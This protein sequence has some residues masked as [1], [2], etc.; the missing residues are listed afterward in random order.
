MNNKNNIT[1]RSR[2]KVHNSLHNSNIPGIYDVHVIDE[3]RLTNIRLDDNSGKLNAGIYTLTVNDKVAL[4]KKILETQEKLNKGIMLPRYKDTEHTIYRMDIPQYTPISQLDTPRHLQSIK[5]DR[6]SD[7][8]NFD[9]VAGVFE[10]T[11]IGFAIIRESEKTY[12]CDC[13]AFVI[14]HNGKQLQYVG[15]L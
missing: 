14:S 3:V 11:I 9:L 1:A 2:V 4:F 7:L 8:T 13:D 10:I 15:R 5:I 6:V 12:V